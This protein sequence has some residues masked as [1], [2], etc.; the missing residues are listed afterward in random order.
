MTIEF[1]QCVILQ[2]FRRMSFELSLC[3]Q[4]ATDRENLMALTSHCDEQNEELKR[5]QE[6]LGELPGLKEKL[7]K[8]AKSKDLLLKT[9]QWGRESKSS[10]KLQL[11]VCSRLRVCLPQ[12]TMRRGA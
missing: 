5:L 1:L 6:E 10:W 8:C 12:L 9:Q 2:T 4:S 7:S 3:R 11:E